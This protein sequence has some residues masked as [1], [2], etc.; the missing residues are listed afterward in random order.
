[1]HSEST[2]DR[3][4][5][6][7]GQR[8]VKGILLSALRNDRLAHAYLF[9]GSE[10]V[11]KDAMAL[12]LARVLHC[13]RGEEEACGSCPSCL[14]MDSLQH[15]EVRLVVPLP[16][17]RGEQSDDGPLDKLTEAEVRALQEELRLKAGNPYHR[18]S[19]A[20]ANIIKISSIREIRRES[21]MSTYDRK[22]R[23]VIISQA[24]AMGD[25]AANTLLKTL[26]EPSGDTM[27]VLTTCRREAL[28]PTIRSRCQDIRFDPLTEEE[29]RSG[30]LDRHNAEGGRAALAARLANGSFTRAV[31]LLDDEVLQER[32]HVL[33]F[34]RHSLS[35]GVLPLI[36]DVER[37]AELREKDAV[38]RFLVLLLMW[39]RDALVLSQGGAV[40]N[41][42]QK[43][44]L[45]RFVARFPDADLTGAIGAV[46]KTISLVRRNAYI[47][48]SIMN[49]A[50]TL[51][52]RILTA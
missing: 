42:D 26:E 2:Q 52:S 35:A 29:I 33:S 43:E 27:L 36:E 24:E 14:R 21:S 7:L 11:G 9:H 10:G 20:R 45:D 3:W 1:M 8:R 48:L 16:V 46:E 28:L 15:P 19:L 44:D 6:V 37:V 25:Q 30:L 23:V 31:E 13:E 40:I 4:P 38:E 22:K 34:V 41:T 5:R 17:G 51:K 47:R 12:E 32:D 50:L 18:I 49:L 39:F